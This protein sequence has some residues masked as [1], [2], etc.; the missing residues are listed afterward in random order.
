MMAKRLKTKVCCLWVFIMIF[1]RIAF[2][3][4]GDNSTEYDSANGWKLNDTLAN[5]HDADTSKDGLIDISELLRVIQLFNVGEYHEECGTED[6]YAP[7]PGVNKPCATS[8]VKLVQSVVARNI[9]R[10][11]I[12]RAAGF[13]MSLGN[14]VTLDDL[15]QPQLGLNIFDGVAV[16]VSASQVDF[17]MDGNA[18]LDYPPEEAVVSFEYI[19]SYAEELS[20]K[21]RSLDTDVNFFIASGNV[22]SSLE[23]EKYF[24]STFHKGIIKIHYD[25]G[26]YEVANQPLLSELDPAVQDNLD[27]AWEERFGTHYVFA[28]HRFAELYVEIEVE[29]SRAR[30][31]NAVR[32]AMESSFGAIFDG[33][34]NVEASVTNFSESSSGEF[35]LKV[36]LRT[37]GGPNIL[38]GVPYSSVTGFSGLEAEVSAWLNGVSSTNA[39]RSEYYCRPLTDFVAPETITAGSLS[40]QLTL[41]SWYFRVLEAYEALSRLDDIVDCGGGAAVFRPEYRHLLN[42]DFSTLA[43][44]KLDAT[45][46]CNLRERFANAFDELQALGPEIRGGLSFGPTSPN[47]ALPS[48]E[49]P[50]IFFRTDYDGLPTAPENEVPRW[51]IFIHGGNFASDASFVFGT[52]DC[53]PPNEPV[54]ITLIGYNSELGATEYEARMN[55]EDAILIG[56]NFD[57]SFYHY[58]FSLSDLTTSSELLFQ[59]GM[60]PSGRPAY[61]APQ[62][63]CGE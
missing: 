58:T 5:F 48:V 51:P 8:N 14:G 47:W 11:I 35:Q 39:I 21:S 34:F 52:S 9:N 49:V 20:F 12:I 43:G 17:I 53:D 6:D 59:R 61:F 45:Y 32:A 4:I 7:G 24:R 31:R 1:A 28:E 46:Y 42:T 56:G 37:F 15:N 63:P 55:P 25:F 3:Q 23:H 41:E 54:L 50:A 40:R 62:V 22:R 60:D 10:P 30:S 29:T 13:P 33:V 38:T 18:E 26:W 27:E 19:D 57:E 36:I 44:D 2:A 16:P